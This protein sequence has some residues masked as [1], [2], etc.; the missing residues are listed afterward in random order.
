[1]IKHHQAWFV[2]LILGLAIFSQQA[3]A[4]GVA[5]TEKSPKIGLVLSGGGARGFAHIGVIK[6]LEEEGIDVDFIGGTSMGSIVGGLYAMGYSID[7][8]EEL[9]RT[10]NWDF[11]LNDKIERKNLGFYEKLAQDIYVFSIGVQ[12]KKVGIPPGLVY[13]QNVTHLLSTL[14]T[15]SFQS[16]NFNDL[17]KPFLCMATDL[18]TGKAIKLDTGNLA[19]AIRASMSVPSA[20]APVKYGPYYL[21][22]GGVL[23][24]FPA[25]HVKDLGADILIGVDIQTPL[26]EKDEIDNLL[27]VLTQSIFLNGEAKFKENVELIDFMIKP[28]IDPFT[29][30]DFD[31]ADSLI[32]RGEKKARQM[33]PQLRAFMDSMGIQRKPVR[34]NINAFPDMDVIYVDE[35]VF[36]GNNRISTKYLESKLNIHSGDNISVKNLD[37]RIN[38]LYGTKLFHTINYRLFLTQKGETRIVVTI[39]EASLLD[40]N[41]STHYNDYTQAGLLLNLTARNVGLKNG[42]L[43]ADLAL[44]KVTRFSVE[45]VVDNGLK[46]GFGSRFDVF[47]QYGYG[48]ADGKRSL[49]FGMNMAKF[50]LFSLMTFKNELRVRGGL[51][52]ETNQIKDKVSFIEFDNLNNLSGDLYVDLLFDSY[53][54]IYFPNQGYK[55][56]GK[57]EFGLGNATDVNLDQ[58]GNVVYNNQDFSYSA[59][60]FEIG[61][62]VPLSQ[63]FALRPGG[64]FRKIVGDNL[65]FLK[66]T[67][68]GGFQA[69]YIPHFRPFPGVPFMELGGNASMLADLTLR[70]RFWNHHYLSLTGSFLSI[71]LDFNKSIEKNAF[72]ENIKLSYS[73]NTG[74][75]PVIVSAARAFP[76]RSWVFD[77]SLGF[78]F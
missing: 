49:S 13:G 59:L 77:L 33:I 36:T 14:A 75:G 7:E 22:D 55:L 31:R 47:N 35:V 29:A 15:P 62:I 27:E 39:E 56:F 73:L 6:V 10:Q 61:G 43:S 51:E 40:I 21:V 5:K 17:D 34:G 53:D 57:L 66:E 8:I 50:D 38:E 26:L 52:F 4:Q 19:V 54:Q 20:F 48:Y 23:N 37:Q 32:A 44:G 67:S 46:L 72:Y 71:D 11:V 65:P 3:F 74:F 16:K 9:A 69:T 24:N 70:Y 28:E 60:S 64:Y 1:M 45:Y 41:V 18:L 58:M 78:W 68:F 2:G 12:G 63:H 25:K 30:L 76:N 42:R